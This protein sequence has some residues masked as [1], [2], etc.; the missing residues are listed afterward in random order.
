MLRLIKLNTK[1]SSDLAAKL[2]ARGGAPID[3]MKDFAIFGDFSL[4]LK[5]IKTFHIDGIQFQEE[6]LRKKLT[7]GKMI[8]RYIAKRML[9]G[10]TDDPSEFYNELIIVFRGNYQHSYAHAACFVRKD[11]QNTKQLIFLD[12]KN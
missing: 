7:P 4:S 2:K 3:C 11:F 9:P 5:L 1:L 10:P 8:L 12:C 6:M